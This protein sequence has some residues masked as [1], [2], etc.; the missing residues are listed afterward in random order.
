VLGADLAVEAERAPVLTEQIDDLDQRI[1]N[2]YIR[3]RLHVLVLVRPDV[4]VFGELSRSR[5]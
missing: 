2:L 5:P 4:S 3:V 1:A